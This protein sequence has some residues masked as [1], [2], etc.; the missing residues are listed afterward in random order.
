MF[1]VGTIRISIQ[2][3][4]GPPMCIKCAG[5]ILSSSPSLDSN[6]EDSIDVNNNDEYNT[7]HWLL[8]QFISKQRAK[9]W[10]KLENKFPGIN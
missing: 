2:S 1:G 6:D 3:T 4:S 8:E 5:R 7:L 9:K 10:K